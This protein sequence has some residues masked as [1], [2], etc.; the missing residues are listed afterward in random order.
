VRAPAPPSAL[1]GA[2]AL[3]RADLRDRDAQLALASGAQD[4][5]S[6]RAGLLPG[7]RALGLVPGGPRQPPAG[8]FRFAQA[9]SPGPARFL[10]LPR[11]AGARAVLELARRAAK[12]VPY[13]R[14]A[15]DAQ[16]SV[17]RVRRRWLPS[18]RAGGCA[19]GEP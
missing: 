3:R 4:S 5:L 16:G 13:A 6:G 8:G 19:G 14:R 11:R 1:E 9:D 17:Q 18:A 7:D 15:P 2:T 12:A 10:A